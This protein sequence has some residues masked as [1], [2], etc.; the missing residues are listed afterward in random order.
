MKAIINRLELLAALN[1]AAGVVKVRTPKPILLCVKL[2]AMTDT[3]VVGATDLE[4]SVL[5]TLRLVQAEQV[6]EIAVDAD[7]LR[8][9]IASLT[10][11]TV[12]IELDPDAEAETAHVRSADSHF[13]INTMPPGDFPPVK[14]AEG[15]ETFSLTGEDVRRMIAQTIYAVDEINTNQGATQYP[16][17]VMLT[18]EKTRVDITGS[19][20]KRMALASTQLLIP[21][22][23]KVTAIIP[24]RA[25][26]LIVKMIESDEDSV[27]FHVGENIL[28]VVTGNTTVTT[29]LLEGACTP[30]N[31]IIPLSFS[32]KV[33]ADAES[34]ASIVYRASLAA[35]DMAKG[36]RMKFSKAGLVVTGRSATKGQSVVNYPCRVEGKDIEIGF[37]PKFVVAA[38]KALGADEIT[39][40]MNE[41]NR[42]AVIRGSAGSLCIMMPV[43]LN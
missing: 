27:H 15:P 16:G 23:G 7:G 12:T 1:L 11:D 32:R 29:V 43:N 22:S 37:N 4:M 41:P 6:G 19:D 21:L 10:D 36:V 40:E 28:S 9:I 42:P 38:I 30:H 25:A 24:T 26:N 14:G 2:T 20:G 31:D 35:D 5:A 3:V 18:A 13:K 34:L 8:S 17:G 33:T 39:I